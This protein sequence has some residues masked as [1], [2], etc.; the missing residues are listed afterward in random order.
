MSAGLWGFI[1]Y[2][3]SGNTLFFL[4][5]LFLHV[6]G[7]CYACICICVF[8][9]VYVCRDQIS[10]LG[11]FLTHFLLV[12]LTR[13]SW[14]AWSSLLWLLWLASSSWDSLPESLKNYNDRLPCL[15]LYCVDSGAPDSSL[16][17][18]S[19][20]ALT[21]F[22]SQ[23]PY[24]RHVS[25]EMRSPARRNTKI[26][27]TLKQNISRCLQG[28]ALH[29]CVSLGTY[30]VG[31]HLRLPSGASLIGSSSIREKYFSWCSENTMF[32]IPSL[33]LT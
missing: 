11:F 29:Q 3:F 28:W 20:P 32:I 22:L 26:E 33:K 12:W 19:L 5:F 14:W 15:P 8:V 27:R 1:T 7:V 16:H 10:A 17:M 31:S 6:Y 25:L 18:H 9:H 23:L 2:K 24:V 4:W 21:C 30:L 13:V